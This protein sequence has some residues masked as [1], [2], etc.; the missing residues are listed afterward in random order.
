MGCGAQT[1]LVAVQ[2]AFEGKGVSI[3]TSLV[4]FMQT[5]GETI[6]LAIGNNVF[7]EGLASRLQDTVP[8]V[9]PT[10]VIGT[11]ASGLQASMEKLY[12]PQ[13]TR[14][15]LETYNWALQQVFPI[16][17]IVACISIIGALSMEWTSVKKNKT[18]AVDKKESRQTLARDQSGI[19]LD[20]V[21]GASSS[22]R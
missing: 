15:T 18:K 8:N 20:G 13:E 10:V 2:T 3:G 12:Y 17:L 19:E 5:L 9:D 11:G 16:G 21:D 7:N 22:H 14:G 1:G 4:V 6:F